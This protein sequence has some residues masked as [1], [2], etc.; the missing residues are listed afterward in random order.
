V[1]DTAGH[2]YPALAVAEAFRDRDP[3]ARILFLGTAGSIAAR[4][5]AREGA[6]LIPVPG[7]PLRR[8]GLLGAAV[9][10]ARTAGGVR[11]ARQVFTTHGTKLAIG[12]GGFVT[13]G[14]LAAAR[15][16]GI[17]TAIHEANVDMGLANLMLRPLVDH[18]FVAHEETAANAVAVGVPIRRDILALEAGDRTPPNGVLRLVVMSGSRGTGFLERAMPSVLEAA[19]R[20]GLSIDVRQQGPAQFMDGMAGTYRWAHAAIARAGASSIGELAVAGVPAVL[21]PL[22]DA[23]ADHQSANARRWSLAGAGPLVEE[24]HWD[25]RLVAEWLHILATNPASWRRASNA[26]R[27]LRQ[28][29][30]AER[31]VDHCLTA[32]Q[33]QW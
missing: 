18:V 31:L 15:S 10:A 22:P 6:T 19:A 14:V 3:D 11:A 23:A 17:R 32:M 29:D 7:A 1:G 33:G 5:L 4:I 16:L 24:R 9:A 27:S 8:A 30:A 25:P 20:H 28:V 21:V 26:A 13:G 2:A 12:F